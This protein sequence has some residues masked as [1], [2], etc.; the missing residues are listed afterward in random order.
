MT[1]NQI[2]YWANVETKRNNEASLAET[3]RH[4]K[5][6]EV[7]GRQ[8]IS[9]Q[10]G[11]LQELA[12]HNVAQERF[13][14]STLSANIG[15]MREQARHNLATEAENTRHNMRQE[16]IGLLQAGAASTSAEASRMNA[17]ANITNA[18]TNRMNAAT[19]ARNAATNEFNADVNRYST[20]NRVRQGYIS[21]LNSAIDSGVNLL[22]TF[23][24]YRAATNNKPKAVSSSRSNNNR[25]K[26]ATNWYQTLIGRAK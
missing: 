6:M 4:N 14:Q 3:T 8:Q 22:G 21:E 26:P 13:N 20:E 12:R 5:E 18:A 15:Q 19:N 25:P 10:S 11:N 16:N 17:S 24:R 23:T 2:A 1:R 9:V 7:Q